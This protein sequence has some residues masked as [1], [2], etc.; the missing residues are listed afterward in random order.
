MAVC[1]LLG[2]L[3]SQ[4]QVNIVVVV[5]AAAREQIADVLVQLVSHG[6]YY[7]LT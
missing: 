3:W 1:S 7:T 5:V 2:W 4:P 6:T